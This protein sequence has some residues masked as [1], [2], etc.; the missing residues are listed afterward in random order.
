MQLVLQMKV[1]FSFED[2]FKNREI[3]GHVPH[4]KVGK[5]NEHTFPEKEMQMVLKHGKMFNLLDNKKRQI[6]FHRDTI[7]HP[8]E[9]HT[10]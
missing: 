3:T 2:L 6:K 5:R 8:A 7:S 10:G 9:Q 4:R 1:K